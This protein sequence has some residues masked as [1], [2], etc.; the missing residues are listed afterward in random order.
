MG[1]ART[2]RPIEDFTDPVVLGVAHFERFYRR[3]YDRA[4]RLAFVLSGSRLGAEDLA[5]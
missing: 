3:E 4:V 2:G 5:Q 1:I